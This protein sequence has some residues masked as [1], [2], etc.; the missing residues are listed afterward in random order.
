MK[1]GLI[2]GTGLLCFSIS[3]YSLSNN[4][5]FDSSKLTFSTN[6]KKSTVTSSF[7]K[8]YNLTHSL[9]NENADLENKIKEIS[10]K[11][12]Y[13]LLGNMNGIEESS[14]EYYKRH[15]DYRKMAVYNYFPKDK[16]SKSGYDE[17]IENY[18]YALASELAIPQLWNAFNELGIVYNSYGDIR[19]TISNNLVI[20][21]VKLPKVKIKEQNKEDPMKY[22][23]IETNLVIYYYFLEVDNEYR[24]AYLYGETTDSVSEYFN[25]IE[26]SEA[27][28]TMAMSTSYESNL[29]TIYNF[30]KLKSMSDEEFNN[31]YNANINNI[32]YL[33]AYYNNIVT[34][35]ANGFFINNGIVVTTWDFLEE[36]LIK[37]QYIS[38]KDNNRKNYNIDGIITVNPDTNVAVIKL[39]EQ[40]RIYVKLG[41]S[42]EIKIE[43]PV[44]TI[45]SKSGVG[46]II[47]K[48]IAISNDDY[49]QTSIPLSKSDEGSPL[50]DKSGNVIG[51]NTSKSTSTSISIAINSIVLKEIQDKFNSLEFSK[52]ETISFDKLKEDYYYVKYS[53]ENVI[54]DIPK[55][56]W[57]TYSKIG[58]IENNI[59]LELVKANYKDKIVSLRYKNNISNYIL[60]MQLAS[61]YKERLLFDGYKEVLNSSSKCIYEN[62]KYKVV[63]MDEFDYLI[64]VV[65]KV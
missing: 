59:K 11:T 26:D 10:K 34:S 19:V 14:E 44:I 20:S 38:I 63:I 16:N 42:S 45:S 17:S 46:L 32:V 1:K 62:N 56:K 48:G 37:A 33:S 25:E 22:D 49:I 12:T 3:V 24:L 57:K 40:S 18:R 55:S 50:F 21:T 23:L 52:I 13:L 15:K 4:F 64:V 39:K 53:N 51:I 6:S 7:N 54:N 9:S 27:P 35:T 2:L 8:D 30:D 41:N 36:V 28:T 31:I 47:Q 5:N 29:S 43:D 61:A 60:S 58:D 65:V